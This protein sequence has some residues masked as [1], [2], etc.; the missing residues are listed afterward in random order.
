MATVS[1]PKKPRLRSTLLVGLAFLTLPLAVPAE[2]GGL[3]E[4]GDASAA[5]MSPQQERKLGED[6]MRKAHRMLRMVDDPELND[7]IQSLGERL[8]AHSAGAGEAYQFFLVDDPSINAFAVPGGFI[9]VNTGL[10]LAAR[11]EG[12]LAAVLAHEITH[13][14]QRHI[15]RLIAES[16]RTSGPAMAALIAAI[17]LAG[18]GHDGADAAVAL[19]S[20][21]M[22]QSR[23]N[24]TRAFEQE[25][26]NLGIGILAGAGFDPRAMPAFFESLQTWGRLNETSLPEFLRTHPI[27][28]TRI[29]ESRQRAE[30]YTK[31]RGGD[32][33]RFYLARAKIRALK[34]N[35]R[36][37]AQDFKKTLED[38]KHAHADAE[39]YGYA[40]A[41][42]RAQQ[43]QAARRVLDELIRAQPNNVAYRLALAETEMTAGQRERALKLYAAAYEKHA[44]SKPLAYRY[45]AALL[46]SGQ[47][48]RAQ[49]LLKELLRRQAGDPTLYKMLARAAGE[50]GELVA[51]HQA[52]AEHYY[53]GG[54]ADAALEQLRIATRFAKGNFYA[55]SSIEARAQEMKDDIATWSGR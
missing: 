53:L 27:T 39:R 20:A 22:A 37:V 18:T 15:P 30:Q 29:S 40:L 19:T 51:A 44:N 1:A 13:V 3:P 52:L 4:L 43:P 50:T 14:Q 31:A 23:L 11:D 41:L 25:A 49:A 12:E 6:F 24:Y 47:P 55:L 42:S 28:A 32:S 38:G 10:I 21:T 16:K 2:M 46:E 7:Y 35:P 34:G 9:G 36:E 48:K 8:L 5:V 54:N 33:S 26:D 17:L 45:A